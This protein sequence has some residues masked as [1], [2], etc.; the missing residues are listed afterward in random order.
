MDSPVGSRSRAAVG[1]GG[2]VG[3]EDLQKPKH[4]VQLDIKF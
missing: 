3:G 2:G 1:M 4:V